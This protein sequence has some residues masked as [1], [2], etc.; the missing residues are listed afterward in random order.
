M[1]VSEAHI[2]SHRKSQAGVVPGGLI[3]F[4]E[5]GKSALYS[6]RVAFRELFCQL[7]GL[8]SSTT[9]KP[10]MWGGVVARAL[11]WARW[12]LSL[13]GAFFDCPMQSTPFLF[14]WIPS[15]DLTTDLQA[16]DRAVVVIQVTISEPWLYPSR[17]NFFPV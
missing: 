13:G 12:G 9:Q 4:I 7:A 6:K 5:P 10:F 15:T 14:L 1:V 2:I 8:R 3:L 17:W 11:A 16:T